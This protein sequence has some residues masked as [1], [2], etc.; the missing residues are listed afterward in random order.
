MTASSFLLYTNLVIACMT[1][2]ALGRSWYSGSIG[3]AIASMEKIDSVDEKVDH[4]EQNQKEMAEKQEKMVD[5]VVALSISQQREGAEV[6]INELLGQLRDGRG[7][8]VFLSDR[9][10]GCADGSGQK[11]PDPRPNDD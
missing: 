7:V 3:K 2:L 11:G 8:Q 5:G 1:V 9:E 10:V 4:I 6:D